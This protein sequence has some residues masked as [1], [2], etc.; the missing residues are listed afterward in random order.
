M[1]GPGRIRY[2]LGGDNDDS[3]WNVVAPFLNVLDISN[4]N[5]IVM[6]SLIVSSCVAMGIL[7]FTKA[8]KLLKPLSSSCGSPNVVRRGDPK[9]GR[10]GNGIAGQQT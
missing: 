2:N 9:V 1:V 5:D 4:C 10:D 8:A 7:Y 6:R 3:V